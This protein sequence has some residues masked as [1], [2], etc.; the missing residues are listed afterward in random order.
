MFCRLVIPDRQLAFSVLLVCAS[1]GNSAF[2]QSGTDEGFGWAC[3]AV[4]SRGE[5]GWGQSESRARAEQLALA[6]CAQQGGSGCFV[7]SCAT[8]AGS[9][10]VGT[11]A[12]ATSPS[13]A[14]PRVFNNIP[15]REVSAPPVRPPRIVGGITGPSSLRPRAPKAQASEKDRPALQ[16]KTPGESQTTGVASRSDSDGCETRRLPTAE[17]IKVNPCAQPRSDAERKFY[18]PGMQGRHQDRR[19]NRYIKSIAGCPKGELVNGV[20]LDKDRKWPKSRAG[21]PIYIN[22]GQ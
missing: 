22:P 9:S 14:V 12:T 6:G 17:V 10:D 3:T 2:A 7:N 8:D 4:G 11:T 18:V 19:E 16:R 21:G 15:E 13:Q 1:I 20:C 5:N